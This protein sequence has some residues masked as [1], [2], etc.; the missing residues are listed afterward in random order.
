MCWFSKGC[1]RFFSNVHDLINPWAVS[2]FPVPRQFLLTHE[3]WLRST[4][5]LTAKDCTVVEKEE[6]SF[7]VGGDEIGATTLE[8][9]IEKP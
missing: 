3:E 7:P 5:Q 4:R 1:S 6:P 9:S 2:R 8:I